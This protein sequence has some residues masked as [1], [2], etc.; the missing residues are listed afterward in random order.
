MANADPDRVAV[1]DIPE[2]RL[3]AM[4]LGVAG[5]QLIGLAAQLD[6]PDL[7]HDGAKSIEALAEATGTRKAAT[8]RSRRSFSVR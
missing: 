1:D 8:M 2:K 5:T 7:L 4:M 3:L 6:I